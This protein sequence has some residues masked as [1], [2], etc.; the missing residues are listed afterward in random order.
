MLTSYLYSVSN[1]LFYFPV[2]KNRVDCIPCI[3]V[4]DTDYE[5]YSCHD[6][7]TG[8]PAEEGTEEREDKAEEEEETAEEVVVKGDRPPRRKKEFLRSFI[9]TYY[10]PFLMKPLV[11]AIIVRTTQLHPLLFLN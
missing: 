1:I 11:K 10:A 8:I 5:E 6:V 7:A 4:I 2:K 9:D 3:E